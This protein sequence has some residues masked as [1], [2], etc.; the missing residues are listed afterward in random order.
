MA[1]GV[2]QL[3]ARGIEDIFLTSEPEIT[4]FKVVYRRHTNF[5]K[6]ELDMT[7]VNRMDFGKTCTMKIR[8]NG[9]LL[10]R[11]F[12]VINLPQINVVL[13]N[14]T[15]NEVQ[16]LL[17]DTN[18]VWQTNKKADD[19]FTPADFNQVAT[20]I[21][22]Q[23]A[24]LNAEL[25]Q[26]YNM[27]TILTN[28]G[29]LDPPVWLAN[30]G[31]G[32][33]D[34]GSYEIDG[35]YMDDVLR[36]LSM[37]T[38]Y[39][40]EYQFIRAELRDEVPP[41]PLAPGNVL[42]NL[43]F[44]KFAAFATSAELN[45]NSYNGDNL[46]FIFNVD[47]STYIIQTSSA[48]NTSTSVFLNGIAN[49]YGG[50]PY[51]YLDA[52]KIFNSTL[53][54]NPTIVT[55]QYDVTKIKT[56]LIQDIRYDLQK[57]ILLLTNI[58]KS[59][60][61]DPVNI[62]TNPRFMF[63]R[64]FPVTAGGF[65]TVNLWNNQSQQQSSSAL[66]SDNFTND[67]ILA[68][69]PGEPS[70][71]YHPMSVLVNNDV[72][73]FNNN[74]TTLFR[75]SKFNDYF[76][77]LSLWTRTDIKD[78]GFCI[79]AITG[80]PMGTVP[81]IYARTNY[82]NFIP[83]LTNQDIPE[84]IKHTLDYLY[85]FNT[86]VNP[87]LA[88][89]ISAITTLLYPLMIAQSA[90]NYILLK[91]YICIADDYPTIKEM[92]N[93][94]KTTSG[95]TGDILDVSIIRQNQ[96]IFLNGAAY[97]LPEWVYRRYEKLLVDFEV[98]LPPP[99]LFDYTTEIKPK[100]DQTAG[101]FVTPLSKIPSFQTFTNQNFNLTNVPYLQINT[102]SSFY[103]D[104]ISSIWYNIMTGF[105]GNY[106]S[107]YDQ[108]ILGLTVYAED[109]GSELLSYLSD[110]SVN[111]F[112]Q[113][114]IMPH[115]VL[116]Y[117]LPLSPANDTLITSYLSAKLT[118][119]KAD[120][121]FFDANYG[122][123]SMK[124]IP[125]P[126]NLY[127]AVFISLLN[128]IVL[129]N[130]EA[131][132]T[133]YYHVMHGT[134]NDP[135]IKIYNGLIDPSSPLWDPSEPH[136]NAMDI[137]NLASN[138]FNLLITSSAN[139]FNPLTDQIKWELW[140]SIWTPTQSFDQT[141][142]YNKY[143]SFFGGIS[144]NSLYNII[145]IIDVVY[146]GFVEENDVFDYMINIVIDGSLL[147][148]I[149]EL[150]TSTVTETNNNIVNYINTQITNNQ[151]E[152]A[153]LNALLVVLRAGSQGGTAGRFAW[154]EYLGHYIIDKIEIYIGDQL[155]DTHYGEWLQFWHQLS[156]RTQ[157]E[158]GY[159]I[160]IGN[161]PQLYTFDRLTKPAY[162]LV[163]PLRFWFCNNPGS[164]LP[165]VAMKNTD[166]KV[167]VKLRELNQVAYYDPFTVFVSKPKI[168]GYMIGEFIFLEQEERSR[169]VKS[170]HEYLIEVLQYNGDIEINQNSFN[171]FDIPSQNGLFYT[172]LYFKNCV[173]EIVWALQRLAFI[174]GSQA[175]GQLKY[176]NY[177]FRFATNDLNPAKQ[178]KIQFMSRDREQFKDIIFYNYI[179]PYRYHTS[180]PSEGINN[181]VFSIK[182]EDFQQPHGAVNMGKIDDT[183]IVVELRDD[184]LA[185]VI[186][187]NVR[188]RWPIYA[189][190]YQILRIMS[191]LGGIAFYY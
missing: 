24:V 140:N 159:N 51:M 142:E 65:N 74:N 2:I 128:Y 181:Y 164:S 96:F 72:S 39:S 61:Y 11:L 94:Y 30:T 173:K 55:S 147:N 79:E 119:F 106:N 170:K 38:P 49:T 18:I 8:K 47:T 144:S 138:D 145:T 130:I 3:V 86:I 73:T 180:V 129:D 165:L 125:V 172:K 68:P 88:A 77:Q 150:A 143:Q 82:M 191:G 50:T 70:T 25:T 187:N 190:S 45:P 31:N 113:N 33:G 10:H 179:V 100:L 56:E 121:T 75:T 63:Y 114:A 35:S 176:Y 175:N 132:E 91:S 19:P 188:F 23:I 183:S 161:V 184:V 122:L 152:I 166:I 185:S 118:A 41:L 93:T 27:L 57:N 95:P 60:K 136:N 135:V 101:L 89:S 13:R 178:A 40:I 76:N 83:F 42:I 103:S 177:G 141:V 123:L 127:F 7:F 174:D 157:K 162:Q 44:N 52:Y 85:N 112:G 69:L 97:T 58:Y 80:S 98:G 16:Q 124:F 109:L 26:Y 53:Q 151:N 149:P 186:T 84:A 163:I 111:Y 4:F 182:P 153:N 37:V 154:I 107:L 115:P 22:Q 155:I 189:I 160:L 48:I 156:K 21:K 137:V 167:N 90:A 102:S 99:L 64:L 36:Y 59:L 5:S 34:V 6:T 14:L 139:P 131:D 158:R 92:I 28:G 67:F 134:P 1:G 12:L 148:G 87:A 108:N 32:E 9:D 46:L 104:A 43:L 20:L 71:I 54:A 62:D 105:V 15:I 168:T 171:P 110:I 78:S 17:A 126:A 116:Y 81:T 120:L 29:A 117:Y 169:I 133:K 146:N 66:L